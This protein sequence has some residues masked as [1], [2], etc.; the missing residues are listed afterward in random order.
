M[1]PVNS[2][3]TYSL[4]PL[5]LGAE[6]VA[7]VPAQALSWHQVQ[8]PAGTLARGMLAER[9]A[10]RLRAVLEGLLEDH[11]LDDPAQLHFALQPEA[12][13][14]AKVWVAVCHRQWLADALAALQT[15]GYQPQRLVPEWTPDDAD[16]STD[17]PAPAAR[18]VIGDA[19]TAQL[20]WTDAQGVHTWP[21]TG[22]R[23]D[24]AGVPHQ[25]QNLV[26]AEAELFAE[27]AV[28][29]LAEQLLH[30]TARVVTPDQR[31]RTAAQTDWNLA[32]FDFSRR[33]PWLARL[34]VAADTVWRTPQWRPARWATVALV[35]VQVLGVNA[36]AWRAK[37]Q[38]A[39]QRTAIRT[40]LTQTFP[41]VTVV[42]DAPVQM[43]R[44]LAALQQ[45]SG[46]AAATDMETLL[47][48]LGSANQEAPAHTAP[49]T[50]EYAGQTMRIHIGS[51]TQDYLDSLDHALKQRGYSSRRDGDTVVLQAQGGT[52]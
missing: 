12:R 42:V 1:S 22:V 35:V 20:V 48:A 25:L 40:T 9:S 52:P 47:S 4:T 26:P 45:S 34:A 37:S 8:L 13:N 27:P 15:T 29:Q 28:A 31:L 6:T 5:A 7:L 23:S 32:Q 11:L 49:T 14:D 51:N 43:Q 41:N 3:M 10:P 16:S 30:R 50:V 44:A 18:W 17:Q 19:D 38:L 24:S 46:A 2:P 21:L 36:F 33:N 39:Q